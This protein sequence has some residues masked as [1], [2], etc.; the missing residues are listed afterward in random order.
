MKK[1]F[2]ISSVLF[3]A[4]IVLSGG[5]KH[6]PLFHQ[7]LKCE[8]NFELRTAVTALKKFLSHV[9]NGVTGKCFLLECPVKM[10]SILVH[11]SFPAI[12]VKDSAYPVSCSFYARGKAKG[13]FGFLCY[14]G[15]RRCVYP[16]EMSGKKFEIDSP[17]KWVKFT[18][19]FIPRPGGLFALEVKTLQPCISITGGGK[20]FLDNLEQEIPDPNGQ[21]R[22]AD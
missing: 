7:E 9:E 5:E 17:D 1:S 11:S 20:I 22:I 4:A 3:L 16:P 10:K 8:S 14:N 13:H 6:I 21:I 12:P 19:T 2:L 18:H 15:K